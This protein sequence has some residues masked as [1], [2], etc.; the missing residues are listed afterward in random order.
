M[1]VKI[2]KRHEE[3]DITLMNSQCSSG[4]GEV[5]NTLFRAVTR[6]LGE[7]HCNA[8][9]QKFEYYYKQQLLCSECFQK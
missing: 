6:S 7:E 3:E 8:H 9:N 2:A 1:S 4:C 5:D